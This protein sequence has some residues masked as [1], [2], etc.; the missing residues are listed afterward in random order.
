MRIDDGG[1]IIKAP[2]VA[3]E[4]FDKYLPQTPPQPRKASNPDKQG[5]TVTGTNATSDGHTTITVTGSAGDDNLVVTQDGNGNVTVTDKDTHQTA[6]FHVDSGTR[7]VIDGGGGNDRI[8]ASGT[9]ETYHTHEDG[10][11]TTHTYSL[12][13]DGQEGNDELIAGDG[14]EMLI[15]GEGKD[16]LEGGSGNDIL[17]GGD[18]KDVLYGNSGCDAL[19]GDEGNDYLDGGRD[20]DVCYGDNGNDIVSGGR[21]DDRIYGGAGQDTLITSYGNDTVIDSGNGGHDKIFAKNGDTVQVDPSSTLYT[22]DPNQTHYGKPLGSSIVIV[23]SEHFQDRMNSDIDT[24]AGLPLGEYMLASLDTSGHQTVIFEYSEQNGGA[25]PLGGKKDM[26]LSYP[27]AN[28]NP[29][30]GT[31]AR[32]NINPS[33]R[34][35]YDEVTDDWA[36]TPPI[37][38]LFHEM[39]HAQD[40]ELGTLIPLNQVSPNPGGP[41]GIFQR[42]G[43]VPTAPNAERSAVGLPYNQ[44]GNPNTNEPNDR[45]GT[46]NNFRDQL[47]LPDRPYY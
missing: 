21:G 12:T 38:V 5:F 26:P 23:G 40:Y 27:D 32:I 22:V 17:I 29:G 35:D 31:D 33:F 43:S 24:L 8:D 6:T 1:T 41:R 30:P 45:L 19:F 44:D 3:P 15:G 39:A 18:G 36:D 2:T 13:L 11:T 20:N 4:N 16:Y 28:G 14:G 37:V 7:V 47:G 10:L 25:S 34:H 9:S 42:R 46:E